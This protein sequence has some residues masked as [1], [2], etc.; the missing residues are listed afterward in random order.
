MFKKLKMPGKLTFEFDISLQVKQ[1]FL[2]HLPYI[3]EVEGRVFLWQVLCCK[4]VPKGG[5]WGS[6]LT[7]RC[8]GV[9][10]ALLRHY[11]I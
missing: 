9:V 8:L 11:V 10:S 6:G 3:K 2:K 5:G 7:V 4:F 1:A